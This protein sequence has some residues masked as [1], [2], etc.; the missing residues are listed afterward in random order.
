MI[1]VQQDNHRPVSGAAIVV[2]PWTARGP[3]GWF[4]KG[5]GLTAGNTDADGVLRIPSVRL[6]H[7]ARIQMIA[8]LN[9]QQAAVM[10]LPAQIPVAAA[11]GVAAAAA[12][13]SVS[14]PAV[15][16]GA[17]RRGRCWGRS[18]A[19]AAVG[20]G[21]RSAPASPSVGVTVGPLGCLRVRA[22]GPFG[23]IRRVPAGFDLVGIP[24]WGSASLRPAASVRECS[25]GCARF[26]VFVVGLVGG[27]RIRPRAGKDVFLRAGSSGC[28]WCLCVP[29]TAVVMVGQG[30]VRNAH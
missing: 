27:S 17:V 6:E 2:K 28:P 10:V 25:A 19:A 29:R 3:A 7:V 11:A 30:E 14:V 15:V 18:G 1:Q 12:G 20:V 4:L 21:R 16:A 5:K 22:R 8:S 24:A 26:P 23:P 13:V 9:G